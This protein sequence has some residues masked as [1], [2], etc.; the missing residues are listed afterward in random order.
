LEP[1]VTAAAQTGQ[2][3]VKFPNVWPE[4]ILVS[5]L[6][7]VVQPLIPQVE[8]LLQTRSAARPQR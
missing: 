2:F 4:P 7:L 1:K 5:T 8:L 3:Q 6:V